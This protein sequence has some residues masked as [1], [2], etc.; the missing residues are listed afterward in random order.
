MKDPKI[1]QAKESALQDMGDE[2]DET[3]D[4]YAA[5]AAY[6]DDD[7]F[8]YEDEEDDYYDDDY[9]DDDYETV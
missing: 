6:P 8:L 5:E 3:M 2:Y 4:F 7:N 1:P 9:Y